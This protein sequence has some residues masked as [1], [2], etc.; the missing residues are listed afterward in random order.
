MIGSREDQRADGLALDLP[1]LEEL[2][3]LDCECSSSAGIDEC[4]GDRYLCLHNSLYYQVRLLSLANGFH[5]SN[6]RNAFSHDY[7]VLPL[8]M[9]QELIDSKT[10]PTIDTASTINRIVKRNCSLQLAHDALRP[11]LRKNHLLHEASH[12]VAFSV[13]SRVLGFHDLNQDKH[14]YVVLCLM[15]EAYANAIERIAGFLADTQTHRF[16]FSLNSF[17]DLPT[18]PVISQVINILDVKRLMLWGMLVF[19]RLN[20]NAPW[21]EL[22][23]EALI[24]DWRATQ[25][26]P[27]DAEIFAMRVVMQRLST[28]LDRGFIQLT[29]P[30]FFRYMNCEEAYRSICQQGI[31]VSSESATSLLESL[32]TLVNITCEKLDLARTLRTMSETTAKGSMAGPV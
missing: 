9:L 20:C 18:A 12:C 27:P 19:L 16:F 14:V 5:Y 13:L 30:S 26:A 17:V 21:T 23:T 15:C 4:F 3:Q 32:S 25:N 31:S 29:N 10:I 11:I 7:D 24:Q 8:F 6:E 22:D 28:S 2:L 1:P